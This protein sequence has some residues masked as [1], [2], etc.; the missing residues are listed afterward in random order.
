MGASTTAVLR[1]GPFKTEERRALHREGWGDSFDK[2][3]R[4]LA[5]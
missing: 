5:G 2:L 4:L 3:E 1:Q